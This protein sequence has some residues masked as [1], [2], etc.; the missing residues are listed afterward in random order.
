VYKFIN[1][2][3]SKRVESGPIKFDKDNKGIFIR[4]DN[5]F[6]MNMYLRLV[7]R[8]LNEKGE[9]KYADELI[10]VFDDTNETTTAE[11][12]ELFDKI[13]INYVDDICYVTG[14]N[15][16]KLNSDLMQF[17]EDWEGKYFDHIN[18]YKIYTKLANLK[19]DVGDHLSVI[20]K[21]YIK[22]CLNYFH[23]RK[24]FLENNN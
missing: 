8:E 19:S 18:A 9:I 7:I 12:I 1:F 22:N 6:G 13:D 20:S 4:G 14:Y 11:I 21:I 15:G 5:L 3:N 10:K 24:E 16:C 2:D 17:N 23:C